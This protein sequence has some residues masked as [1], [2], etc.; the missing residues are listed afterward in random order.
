MFTNLNFMKNLPALICKLCL[1]LSIALP[2]HAGGGRPSFSSSRSSFSGG[3]RSS[4]SPSYR[5][6]SSA[7]SRSFSFRSSPSTS[8]SSRPAAAPRSYSYSAPKASIAAPV[9]RS[10]TKRTV[11][12]NHYY[13]E[14]G[15]SSGGGLSLTDYLVLYSLTSRDHGPTYV[16]TQ[17]TAQPV[18]ASAA[19]GSYQAPPVMYQGEESHFWRNLLVFLGGLGLLYGVIRFWRHLSLGS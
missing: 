19:V 5:S 15:H 18:M 9:S 14:S 16:N 7:P 11:I 3:F 13:G 4:S 6:F 8:V 2:G 17:P 1:M 12:N 10:T